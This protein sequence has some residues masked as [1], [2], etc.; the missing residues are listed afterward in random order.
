LSY[1][2]S[3]IALLHIAKT[4]RW[5]HVD[6]P[7]EEGTQTVVLHDRALSVTISLDRRGLRPAVVIVALALVCGFFLVTPADICRFVMLG[8]R[9]DRVCTPNGL[10]L[11]YKTHALSHLKNRELTS[12]TRR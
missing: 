4:C 7:A 5:W 1:L 9:L 3:H 2:S 8:R 12:A 11:K 10:R 6:A